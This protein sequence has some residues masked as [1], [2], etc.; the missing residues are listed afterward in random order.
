MQKRTI[1]DRIEIDP[2]TGDIGVRLRKQ[3]VD[4]DGKVLANE[5]H[6]V[7]LEADTDAAD[8]VGR[9]NVHLG[10]MGFPA[11]RD[12]DRAT[13][14]GALDHFSAMRAAKAPEAKARREARQ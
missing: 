12:E 3:V 2:Q 1:I 10:M 9:V 5:P 8:A 11:V 6:R 13:L 14:D 7:M 4:D